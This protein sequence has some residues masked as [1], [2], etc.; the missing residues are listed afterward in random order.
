MPYPPKTRILLGCAVRQPKTGGSFSLTDQR[1]VLYLPYF[2]S[3]SL[4]GD[5]RARKAALDIL[6]RHRGRIKEICL[7]APAR[8]AK[9]RPAVVLGD[10]RRWLSGTGY[11]PLLGGWRA[12]TVS[13]NTRPA[14]WR[15]RLS[16][17]SATTSR[18]ANSSISYRTLL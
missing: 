9:A 5:E 4:R 17:N 1:H 7:L 2:P 12:T 18:S 16:L 14:G 13:G 6:G 3:Y 15:P 8:L 10:A 11:E